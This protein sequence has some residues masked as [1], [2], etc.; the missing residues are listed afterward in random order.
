VLDNR[1]RMAYC[2]DFHKCTDDEEFYEC[3]R[4]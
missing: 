2:N 4:R 3:L 1:R